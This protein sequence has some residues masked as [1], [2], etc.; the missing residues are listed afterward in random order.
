MTPGSVKQAQPTHPERD[1]W[2]LKMTPSIGPQSLVQTWSATQEPAPQVNSS[3]KGQMQSASGRLT[4]RWVSLQR[5]GEEQHGFPQ[6][7][8]VAGQ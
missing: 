7:V 3:L 1:G 5:I 6:V 4:Q 8:L 2:Q